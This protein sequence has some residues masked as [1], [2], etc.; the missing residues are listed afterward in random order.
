VSP[1]FLLPVVRNEQ[2]CG[3]T[4][5]VITSVPDFITMDQLVI[6]E[7][8]SSDFLFFVRSKVGR[9]FSYYCIIIYEIK[10]E[11]EEEE[12]FV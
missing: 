9:K 5:G 10:E 3:I 4:A 12:E 6:G 11:E 1:V 2:V 7:R 8:G